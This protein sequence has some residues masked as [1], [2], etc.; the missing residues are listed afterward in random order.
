MNWLKK[1]LNM[2]TGQSDAPLPDNAILIDVRSQG[3]FESGHIEGAISIPLDNISQKI[4]SVVTDKNTPVIV[5]CQS[6][7]RSSVARQALASAGYQQVVN[8]G[9][10]GGLSMRLQKRIVRGR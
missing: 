8:G 7:M 9:G 3:E 1:V 6:G 4:G 2:L 10:V 5:Y